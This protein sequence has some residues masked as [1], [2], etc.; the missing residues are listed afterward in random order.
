MQRKGN[1]QA[2]VLILL[3]LLASC[4]EPEQAEEDRLAPYEQSLSSQRV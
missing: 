3:S 2:L 4:I 1:G